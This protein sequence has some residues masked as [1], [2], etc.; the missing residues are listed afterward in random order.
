MQ[1]ESVSLWYRMVRGRVV[2]PQCGGVLPAEAGGVE[3]PE[4]LFLMDLS[5]FRS[6]SGER[7]RGRGRQN[8]AVCNRCDPV[9]FVEF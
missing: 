2:V 4:Q 7:K 8:A 5:F 9:G 6:K 1:T 3:E